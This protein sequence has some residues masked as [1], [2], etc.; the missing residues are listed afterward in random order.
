[1][2]GLEAARERVALFDASSQARLVGDGPDLLGLLHRLSTGDVAGL[3]EGESAQTVV[4]TPKG[5]IVSRLFVHRLDRRVLLVGGASQGQ[6]IV[7]HLARYTFAEKTGLADRTGE[8]RQIGLI[9]PA[10]D[11]AL[12]RAG[13]PVPAPGAL[14]RFTDD[15]WLLGHDGESTAARSIVAPRQGADGWLGPLSEAVAELGGREIDADVV[16][17]ARIL[18]GVPV[19]GAELTEQA[20]P[21]EAGLREAVSFAKGCY[22]GQE[23]VARLEN[24]DKVSRGLVGLRCEGQPSPGSSLVADGRAVGVVTSIGQGIALAYAKKRAVAPGDTVRL[25]E[26][27]PEARVVALPFHDR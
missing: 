19:S 5:R 22:V 3:G 15:V 17:Q 18:A 26:E 23:V 11:S 2:I 12:E 4:T 27:G 10:A 1:M 14:E 24:Y 20:N 25:G 13:L 21:L 8:T 7:E 9:G 6:P 16:R